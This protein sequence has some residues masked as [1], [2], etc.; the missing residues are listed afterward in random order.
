MH[1]PHLLRVLLNE[2]LTKQT[3]RSWNEL[4]CKKLLKKQG[5]VW[6][7]GTFD[8]SAPGSPEED[9]DNAATGCVPQPG[10]YR[11][12]LRSGFR[13]WE[14]GLHFNSFLFRGLPYSLGVWEFN[15]IHLGVYL[16]H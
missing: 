13:G 10:G 3:E 15:S 9:L 7:L 4:N 11:F 16:I 8:K 12:H 2:F 14:M 1:V 5:F 6:C